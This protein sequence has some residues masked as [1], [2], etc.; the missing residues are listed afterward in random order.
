MTANSL[1][2]MIPEMTELIVILI[3]LT[4]AGCLIYFLKYSNKEKPK[5]GIKRANFSEYF[6]D[7]MDLKL[8]WGSLFLIILGVVSLLS[9]IVIELL[10]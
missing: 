8:Y 7:Y 10:L 5:S 9:I 4:L 2:S 3:C 1:I 6:K